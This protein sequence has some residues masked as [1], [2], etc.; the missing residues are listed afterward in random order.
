MFCVPFRRAAAIALL[1]LILTGCSGE[2]PARPAP[3]APSTPS[4]PSLPAS[5]PESA[6]SARSPHEVVLVGAG[7]IATCDGSADSRTAALVD[8]TPGTVPQLLFSTTTCQAP[9]LY[10]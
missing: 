7:D 3:S 9:A 5:A 10:E 2:P 4:A 6:P 1:C 8:R